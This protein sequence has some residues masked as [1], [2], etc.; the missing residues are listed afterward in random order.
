MG[1]SERLGHHLVDD[2]ELHQIGADHLEAD[3]AVLA[4]A[5]SLYRM[6]EHISGLITE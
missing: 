2:A 5:G 6:F 4:C 1:A 3:A